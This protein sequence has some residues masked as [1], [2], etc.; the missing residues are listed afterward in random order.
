MRESPLEQ[1]CKLWRYIPI[2]STKLVDSSVLRALFGGRTDNYHMCELPIG[3]V[4][5]R[6]FGRLLDGRLVTLEMS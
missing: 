2:F 1:S 3:L 4:N 6:F 5:G